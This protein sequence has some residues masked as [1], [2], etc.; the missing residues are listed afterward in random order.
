MFEDLIVHEARRRVEI[1]KNLSKYLEVIV[2]AVKELDG[3]ARVYLFGSVVEG[4]NPLSSD[5]D[6]LVV[7]KL[8]PGE[9][10]A[11][12]WSKGIKSPF[13]IHVVDE[14]MFKVYERRTKLVELTKGSSEHGPGKR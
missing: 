5:I 13:E 1:F 9:V 11:A 2:R 8:K 6:V 10:L 7:T 12:L 3:E 4:R 14:E